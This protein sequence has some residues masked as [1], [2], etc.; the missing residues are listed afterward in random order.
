MQEI[1]LHTLT[2]ILYSLYTHLSGAVL[3]RTCY[4]EN[5]YPQNLELTAKSTATKEGEGS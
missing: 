3:L 5:K 2:D 4:K 1:I